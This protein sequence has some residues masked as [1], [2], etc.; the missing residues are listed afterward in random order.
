MGWI[1]RY[2]ERMIGCMDRMAAHLSNIEQALVMIWKELKFI[3]GTH[4]SILA[5]AVEN[6][7]KTPDKAE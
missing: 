7:F 1:K 3:D 5:A 6:R 4:P 2:A